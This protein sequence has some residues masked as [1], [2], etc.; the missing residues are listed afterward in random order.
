MRRSAATV[1]AVALAL[2]SGAAASQSLGYDA[3]YPQAD[4]YGQ[5]QDAYYDHARVVRVD[6]VLDGGRGYQTSQQDQQRCYSRDDYYAGGYGDDY[7][8]GDR[9]G[10]D[11][12]G[13]D[14]YDD[15][16]NGGYQ[17]GSEN[18]R[19]VA[20]VVGGL[21]GAVLGSKV[22]GGTGRYATSALGTMVGGMAGREI[23]EATQRDRGARHGRVTVC[24]PVPDRYYQASDNGYGGVSAYDVT[25][26]YGG[27]QHTTRTAYHPGDTIRVRVDVRPE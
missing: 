25:Y 14:G 16:N 27:R 23:Y 12:Y 10:N 4:R 15:R 11:P 22:G 3:G 5:A 26:E 19:M 8:A 13:R 9:Y 6:P 24:D 18:G 17:G 21:V 20:T 2:A 1:L 7:R